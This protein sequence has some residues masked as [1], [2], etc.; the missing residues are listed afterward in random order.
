MAN[1]IYF[2]PQIAKQAV[3]IDD[4]K[5]VGLEYAMGHLGID[6]NFHTTD[7]PS[8]EP[9]VCFV[10]TST[11]GP[12][13]MAHYRPDEQT[14]KKGSG[15]KFW[16]GM[17]NDDRPGPDDLRR[18]HLI[19]GHPVKLRDGL[20]WTIPVARS[21]VRGSTLPKAIVLGEDGETFEFEELP[22]YASLCRDADMIFD[23]I[24][25][26]KDMKMPF[27]EAARIAIDAMLINYRIGK[28]E[29]SLLQLFSDVQLW[30]V[31]EAIVDMPTIVRMSEELEQKKSPAAG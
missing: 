20:E 22:E 15:G 24:R 11:P 5:A 7:G 8:G 13:R 14:W 3:S 23:S 10:T 4:L 1:F 18:E 27:Q 26:G 31:M 29:A 17:W 9:G 25:T 19:A 6:S 28:W 2:I 21:I 30:D 12:H 16:V